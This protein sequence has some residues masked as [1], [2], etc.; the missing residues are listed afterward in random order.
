MTISHSKKSEKILM[1][2]V[3]RKC[4]SLVGIQQVFMMDGVQPEAEGFLEVQIVISRHG[5]MQHLEIDFPA[6]IRIDLL[7]EELAALVS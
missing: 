7:K 2:F 6:D 4:I 3:L 5:S 1:S